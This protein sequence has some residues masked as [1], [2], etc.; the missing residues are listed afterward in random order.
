MVTL[1]FLVQS[2]GVQIPVGLPILKVLVDSF[3]R[4]FLCAHSKACLD[5]VFDSVNR[6]GAL[7][8]H[9]VNNIAVKHHC[10]ATDCEGADCEQAVLF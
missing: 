8:Q 6:F 1:L 5:P 9:E 10:E 7:R 3:N 2:F 4:D